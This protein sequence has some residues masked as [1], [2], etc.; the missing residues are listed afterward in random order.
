MTGV[1]R[2]PL[3]IYPNPAKDIVTIAHASGSVLTIVDLVGREVFRSVLKT[4]EETMDVAALQP[5]VYTVQVTDGA[6]VRTVRR[7]VKV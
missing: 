1:A 6:G 5:G 2:A 4:D 3:A 7:V